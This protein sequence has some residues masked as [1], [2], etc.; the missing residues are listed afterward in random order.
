MNWF[1]PHNAFGEHPGLGVLATAVSWWAVDDAGNTITSDAMETLADKNGSNDWTQATA[2]ERPSVVGNYMEYDATND[3]LE[4][5]SPSSALSNAFATGG[6]EVLVYRADSGGEG[7]G[8]RFYEK[9]TGVNI[10]GNIAGGDYSHIMGHFHAT[11]DFNFT[12]PNTTQITYGQDIIFDQRYDGSGTTGQQDTWK[13][14][15]NGVPFVEADAEVNMTSTP[16]GAFASGTA[17]MELGNRPAGDRTFDGR[18]YEYAVWDS[19]LT[20]QQML[21]VRDYLA[22]KYGITLG[23][24]S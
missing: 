22:D 12:F 8:G 6:S 1:D 2:S 20:D 7:T 9:D 15:I 3:I 14:G 23:S 4:I 13:G 10:V 18:I 17:A 16:S 24:Y 21:W 19:V 11:A 5:A